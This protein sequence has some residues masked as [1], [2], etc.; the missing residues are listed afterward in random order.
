MKF[1]IFSEKLASMAIAKIAISNK[2]NRHETF[3]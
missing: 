3:R 2:A 1:L